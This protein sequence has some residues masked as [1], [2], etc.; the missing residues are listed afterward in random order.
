MVGGWGLICLGHYDNLV[1]KSICDSSLLL[2]NIDEVCQVS[3]FCSEIH[4]FCF[5][6]RSKQQNYLNICFG[7]K[8]NRRSKMTSKTSKCTKYKNTT[9]YLIFQLFQNYQ[10]LVGLIKGQFG[11]LQIIHFMIFFF[12]SFP[13]SSKVF[14][15]SKVIFNRIFFISSF[16]K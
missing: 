4:K 10:V 13:E 15:R 7:A 8:L 16:L 14:T 12:Q 1:R 11:H 2:R 9:S 5:D 3:D 6:P